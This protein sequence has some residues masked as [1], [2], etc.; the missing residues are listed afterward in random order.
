M[1]MVGK[2]RAWGAGRVKERVRFVM[3]VLG[4]SEKKEKR[5]SCA[6]NRVDVCP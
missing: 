2:A 5:V 4:L 3:S 6:L 1:R